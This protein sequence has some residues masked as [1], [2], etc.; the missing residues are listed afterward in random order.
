MWAFYKGLLGEKLES[1]VTIKSQIVAKGAV[2]TTEQQ[3]L[4]EC[5]FTREDVKKVLQSIPGEKAPGM[6]GF[7]SSFFKHSWEIVGE[8]VADA[9]LDFFQSGK[10][11][12]VINVTCITLIPKVKSPSHVSD[13]R[14]IS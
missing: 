14:P 3:Q 5:N 2:L 8:E 10:L 4:L 6:D 13:F 12:K 7:N 1:R 9:V 11:L